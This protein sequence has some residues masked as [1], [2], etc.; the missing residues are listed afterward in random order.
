MK[1]HL[2]FAVFGL[3]LFAAVIMGVSHTED[4]SAAKMSMRITPKVYNLELEPGKTY[5]EEFRLSNDGDLATN[6]NVK[7]TPYQIDDNDGKYEAIYN[8]KNEYTEMVDWMEIVEGAKG[9]LE[10]G[11]ET[12]IRFTIKVPDN[13]PGGGQY[14]TPLVTTEQDVESKSEGMSIGQN[15]SIGPVIY[16]M[17]NG[18]TKKDAKIISNDTNGFMLNPPFVFNATVKNEG[19]IHTHMT[20]IVKI[21]PFFGGE[22]IYNNEENPSTALVL[23]GTTW[24]NSISWGADQGAPSIG[25][26]KVESEVKIFDEVS[27]IEK[28]VIICP[29]WVLIL[30]IVF[31]LAVIF[32]IISRVRARKSAKD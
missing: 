10:P 20:Q 32:W 1:K 16:A 13:A 24:Y 12:T 21:F 14:V 19:N 15:L 30:V 18:T 8:V 17:V 11:E 9:R 5:T 23:P 3:G 27:K 6:F 7:P 4:A 2:S 29:M 26:Y 28:L 25:I 22:S 31:I